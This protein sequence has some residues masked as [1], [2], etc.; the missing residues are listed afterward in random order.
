[1]K[2]TVITACMNAEGNPDFAWTEV[3]VPVGDYIAGNHLDR[4]EEILLGDDFEEPFVHFVVGDETERVPWLVEGVKK[5]V[6]IN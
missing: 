2:V 5:Y 1:M 4:V 6:G 3:D